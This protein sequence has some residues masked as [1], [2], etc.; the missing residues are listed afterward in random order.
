VFLANLNEAEL[1]TGWR[2]AMGQADNPVRD[3]FGSLADMPRP[4]RHVCF[5]PEK[6]TL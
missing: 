5:T 4:R 3:R 1:R 6:R 2:Q